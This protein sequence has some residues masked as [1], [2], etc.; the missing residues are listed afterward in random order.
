MRLILFL[1]PAIVFAV[2]C[3]DP[4][5]SNGTVAQPVPPPR[6]APP[7][8]PTNIQSTNP[9][10]PAGSLVKAETGVGKKGRGYGGGFVT[11]PIR[12]YFRAQQRV[13]FLRIDHAMNLFRGFHDRLPETHDEYMRE[14]IQQ[15]Q[16]RLPELPPD[17]EYVYDPEKGELMVRRPQK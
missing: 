15:N 13:E 4:A 11:E 8:P 12:Q 5:G 9:A 14:I 2:G 16:I 10:P 1:L 3:T 6:A 17:E 7:A